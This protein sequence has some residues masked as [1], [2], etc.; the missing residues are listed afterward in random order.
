MKERD[1]T[2]C[3][4]VRMKMP[5]KTGWKEI[6]WFRPYRVFEVALLDDDSAPSFHQGN[7]SYS[8]RSCTAGC[9]SI[10][11]ARRPESMREGRFERFSSLSSFGLFRSCGFESV[12][13]GVTRIESAF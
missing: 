1:Q 10:Q 6:T 7:R 2:T 9:L 13:D 12:F 8:H 5:L 3:P 4:K 11:L